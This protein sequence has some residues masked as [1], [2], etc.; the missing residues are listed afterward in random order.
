MS[1]S[2]RKRQ[3]DDPNTSRK[4]PRVPKLKIFNWSDYTPPP[5]PNTHVYVRHATTVSN[6]CIFE[7]TELELNKTLTHRGYITV[8]AWV[9]T[10]DS[11]DSQT[12]FL[13]P[14]AVPL[15]AVLIRVELDLDP[16]SKEQSQYLIVL[17]PLGG[18]NNILY[19]PHE[20]TTVDSSD[21]L[22]RLVVR[23]LHSR[24]IREALQPN[25][26]EFG[27]SMTALTPYTLIY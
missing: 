25:L 20:T 5:D 4:M 7:T 27:I 17:I 3:D 18:V 22:H 23:L 15:P 2:K 14:P 1:V 21:A 6:K 26:D 11:E 13:D 19:T 24:Q 10:A 8:D 12:F 16:E 9:E